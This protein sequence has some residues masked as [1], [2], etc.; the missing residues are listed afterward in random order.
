VGGQRTKGKKLRRIRT[1]G[2][3]KLTPFGDYHSRNGAERKRVEGWAS[4]F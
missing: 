1:H 4:S 3:K 2:G